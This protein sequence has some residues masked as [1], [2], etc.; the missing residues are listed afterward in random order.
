[1]SKSATAEVCLEGVEGVEPRYFVQSL[2]NNLVNSMAKIH[3]QVMHKTVSRPV[4]GKYRCWSCL[5]E[6]ETGW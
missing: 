4:N 6:F 2:W 5:R 1:M 3:C